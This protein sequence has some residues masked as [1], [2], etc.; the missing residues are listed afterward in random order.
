MLVKDGA[1]DVHNPGGVPQ[2]ARLRN[3]AAGRR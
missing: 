3:G 2:C 1:A